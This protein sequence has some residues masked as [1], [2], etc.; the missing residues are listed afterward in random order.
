MARTRRPDRFR[1][2]GHHTLFLPALL[3]DR[4]PLWR[5]IV[6]GM[7]MF[8]V[9]EGDLAAVTSCQL[10]MV[11]R[12]RFT[13][14]LVPASARGPA[15]FGVLLG[16]AANALHFWPGRGLNSG[17]A[18]AVSLARVLASTWNGR[19]LR[20]ADLT[21]HEG[22]MAMLQY[23]HKSRA[24]RAM[25]TVG[26][27]GVEVPVKDRI[28]E[29]I[30]GDDGS[31]PSRRAAD[32]DELMNRLCTLKARLAGRLPGLP[33]DEELRAHLDRL[34][35][36]TLRASVA[37]GPWDTTTTGGEEVDVD[38]LTAPPEPAPA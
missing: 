29:A 12:P 38:L 2:A 26:A 30:A 11:Q 8:G 25:A 27:D 10:E 28:A 5:R 1:C 20:A 18:S 34:D 37:S 15:T 23:R 19:G 36:V 32:L 21:R 9:N 17:I 6:G 3:G 7:R 35:D 33:T 16:D 13:A 24:W 14:E 4:S 22:L 31:A